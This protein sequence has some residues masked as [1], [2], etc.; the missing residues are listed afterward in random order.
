MEVI[1]GLK[2][3]FVQT[4]GRGIREY[5]AQSRSYRN[6]THPRVYTADSKLGM[7]KEKKSTR[8]ETKNPRESGLDERRFTKVT[9]VLRCQDNGKRQALTYSNEEQKRA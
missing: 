4:F 7:T 3:K 6:R 8:P 5:R 2:M 9:G 1:T